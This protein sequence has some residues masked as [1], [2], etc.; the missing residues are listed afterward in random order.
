ML[1]NG[2]QAL[3][4]MA[5]HGTIALAVVIAATVLAFHGSLDAEAAT[6]IFG[7][8]VGLAGGSASALGA[9]GSVVNGKSV[10]TQ[11]MLAEQ[12]ATNRTAIVS[13]AASPAHKVTASEPAASE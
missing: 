6:A 13:A 1:V 2:R 10:V 12:G 8:A 11:Q 5:L 9:L 7:T 4:V 3:Y